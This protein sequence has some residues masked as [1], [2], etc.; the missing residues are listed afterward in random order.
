MDHS[1]AGK[2]GAAIRLCREFNRCVYPACGDVPSPCWT[3]AELARV[4]A[5]ADFVIVPCA[6]PDPCLCDRFSDG[7]AVRMIHVPA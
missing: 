1:E 2:L 3:D 6:H 5:R 4:G 7:H